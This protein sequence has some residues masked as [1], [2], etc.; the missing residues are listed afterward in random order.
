MGRR[1]AAEHRK[2]VHQVAMRLVSTTGEDV[3]VTAE[4][5]Y[6]TRDPYAV[7]ATFTRPRHEPV[8]WVFGRELLLTGVMERAGSGDVEVYLSGDDVMLKLS[9]PEGSA[10]LAVCATDIRRFTAQTL[11]LVAPGSEFGYVDIDA[12]LVAL[13]PAVFAA[14]DA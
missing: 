10:T 5:R 12:E 7:R 9:S 11:N 14:P 6:S 4:L 13:D 1:I 8:V 2:V 3:P